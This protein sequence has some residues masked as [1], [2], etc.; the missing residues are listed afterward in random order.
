MNRRSSLTILAIFLAAP[1]T[2]QQPKPQL[3]LDDLKMEVPALSSDRACCNGQQ[4]YGGAPVGPNREHPAPVGSFPANAWGLH[5]MHGNVWEWCIDWYAPYGAAE[6]ADPAQHPPPRVEPTGGE[7]GGLEILQHPE[8]GLI[9]AQEVVRLGGQ[10]PGVPRH[11]PLHHAVPRGIG[12]RQRLPGRDRVTP[13][14][15]QQG[16][17]LARQRVARHRP[18]LDQ[19]GAV[20]GD[21]GEETDGRGRATVGQV[22]ALLR[23]RHPSGLAGGRV[24]DAPLMRTVDL[25]QTTAAPEAIFALAAD[26]EQ[27]PR[28]LRHYRYVRFEERTARG[29]IV[30]MSANRPFGPLDWPTWWTSEMRIDP[31]ALTVHYRHIRG[32]TTG[33]NVE[34]KI[35]RTISWLFG[36]RR[37]TVRYERK[38]HHFAAFLSLAATL[39]CYKKLTM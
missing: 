24:G 28:H 12:L 21:A 8:R 39:T 35:E 26:V 33:M 16:A 10:R 1:L 20:A 25:L 23:A 31:S 9:V 37:L 15:R 32:V 5:D 27:W 36:Y 38:G 7:G 14:Q 4:P 19:G 2:A 13:A 29:G 22:L 11:R 34:W 17:D 6:Q 3:Y 30:A 18:V